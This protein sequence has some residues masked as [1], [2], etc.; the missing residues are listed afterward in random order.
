MGFDE[1]DTTD[2]HDRRITPCKACR[3][4][5]IWLKTASGKNM[6]VDADTVRPAD[7]IYDAAKHISHFATCPAAEKFRKPR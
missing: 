4:R 7:E 2:A 3:A 1:D 5:I 6:P